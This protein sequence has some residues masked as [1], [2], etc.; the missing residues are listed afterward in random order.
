MAS[1][2]KQRRFIRRW[3]SRY[4]Y[5]GAWVSD[6]ANRQYRRSE[7]RWLAQFEGAESL[8]RRQVVAL[9][10]WRFAQRQ[11]DLEKSLL[12]VTGP[13]ES[14]HA[15]RCIKSA[16]ATRSEIAALDCLLEE[17]GGIPGWGP[18]IASA[19]LAACRPGTYVVADRRAVK[20]LHAL[21]LY[22]PDDDDDFSRADWWPY[23]RV[24]RKLAHSCGVSQGDVGR[25]LVAAAD[26]APKL[27]PARRSQNGAKKK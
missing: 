9:V 24:C 7:S 5:P 21:G 25:A 6:G 18:E 19:I 22:S 10:E 12:G 11:R 17:S 15:R 16:L 8:K 26:E 14:G 27:P 2:R 1:D 20:T 23:L 13:K 3:R 4:P